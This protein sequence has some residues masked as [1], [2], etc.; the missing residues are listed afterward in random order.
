M[1]AADIDEYI[2]ITI[3]PLDSANSFLCWSFLYWAFADILLNGPVH[4]IHF[5]NSHS[6]FG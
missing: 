4:L 6:G 3:H 1:S 5:A 2:S